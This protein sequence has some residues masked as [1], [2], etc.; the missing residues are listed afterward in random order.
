MDSVTVFRRTIVFYLIL[1]PKMLLPPT[2]VQK[3]CWTPTKI[4]SYTFS[5]LNCKEFS[6]GYFT[7]SKTITTYQE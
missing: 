1:F 4:S 2:S 3:F 5:E 6:K 7:E